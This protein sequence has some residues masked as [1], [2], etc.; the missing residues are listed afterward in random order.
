MLLS[1]LLADEMAAHGGGDIILTASPAHTTAGF[2]AAVYSASSA[3]LRAFAETLQDELSASGVRVTALMPEL[4]EPTGVNEVLGALLKRAPATD[5]AGIAR[6]AFAA[7]R[8]ADKQGIAAWATDA[9]S[10][11]ATLISDSVKGPVRQI[12]S[13]TGEAV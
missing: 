4:V 10:S 11:L 5:P 2:D 7:L 1:R 9:V 8:G 13:P 6:Q 12:I 3:F